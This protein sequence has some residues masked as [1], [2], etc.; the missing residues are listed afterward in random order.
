M[1]GVVLSWALA[2]RLYGRMWVGRR[3]LPVSVSECKRYLLLLLGGK[4]FSEVHAGYGNSLGFLGAGE[5]DHGC[6]SLGASD[7]LC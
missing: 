5:A 4:E 7:W 2:E 1:V 6:C 3:G